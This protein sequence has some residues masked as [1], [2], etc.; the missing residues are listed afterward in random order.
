MRDTV[1]IYLIDCQR[2]PLFHLWNYLKIDGRFPEDA[3]TRRSAS[4][5]NVTGSQRDKPDR[6]KHKRGQC[7]GSENIPWWLCQTGNFPCFHGMYAHLKWGWTLRQWF[8]LHTSL[9]LLTLSQVR[10]GAASW[11]IISNVM[12]PPVTVLQ[13]LR[14]SMS[15]QPFAGTMLLLKN[16]IRHWLAY[17]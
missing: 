12:S 15:F 16:D 4:E 14:W 9:T 3:N 10:D 5:K 7:S 13:G 11:P 1:R 2:L 17:S 8:W 6:S